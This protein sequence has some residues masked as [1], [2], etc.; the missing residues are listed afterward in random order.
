MT[1]N[2]IEGNGEAC[3]KLQEVPVIDTAGLGSVING[4]AARG[5]IFGVS[6]YN[7]LDSFLKIKKIENPDT[8]R[9]AISPAQ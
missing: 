6:H 9:W 1:R 5:C 7:Q 3:K 4:S 8:L 2:E